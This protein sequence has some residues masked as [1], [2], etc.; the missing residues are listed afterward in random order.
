MNG[1]LIILVIFAIVVALLFVPVTLEYVFFY[2]GNM[3]SKFLIKFL[4]Y[5]NDFSKKRKQKPSKKEKKPNE[6]KS[7]SQIIEDVKYYKRLFNYFKRDISLILKYAKDKTV[8]IKK[9]SIDTAFAGKDPMQTGIYTGVVNATAYNM[10]AVVNNSV[11]IDEWSVNV[12]PDFNSSAFVDAKIHCIL[13]TKLVHIIVIL[14]KFLA[15][16]LKY[17]IKKKEI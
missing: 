11:G 5:K 14:I 6:K 1:V 7:I 13:N 2:D 15:I 9:V 12:A 17:R 8:K 4:F 16:F 3:K 10:V